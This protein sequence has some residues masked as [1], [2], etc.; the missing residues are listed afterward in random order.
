MQ[1]EMHA[2]WIAHTHVLEALL[3]LIFV[4]DKHFI[5]ALRGVT[6]TLN[7]PRYILSKAS[8]FSEND[9][10]NILSSIVLCP[11]IR[12]YVCDWDARTTAACS[13]AKSGAW[14]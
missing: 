5:I 6:E 10:E 3:R 9:I 13:A 14:T 12:K 1:L 11:Q 2:L 4:K 8:V 7:V